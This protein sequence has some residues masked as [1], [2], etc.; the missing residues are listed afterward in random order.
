[1]FNEP[2]PLKDLKKNQDIHAHLPYHLNTACK[3]LFCLFHLYNTP[4]GCTHFTSEDTQT[5]E[6]VSDLPKVV[7]GE[8]KS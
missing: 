7:M 6:E 2:L 5:P 1:M 8:L 4:T 3:V